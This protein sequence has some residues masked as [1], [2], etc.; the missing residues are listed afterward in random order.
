MVVSGSSNAHNGGDTVTL[1]D[2]TR[3]LRRQW[4]S[5]VVGLLI[6]L[7]L[8]MAVLAISDRVYASRA[9]VSVNPIVDDPFGVTAGN[10]QVVGA[11]EVQIAQ[12]SAVADRAAKTLA[13]GRSSADLLEQLTVRSPQ[14]SS[15]LEF[16]FEAP[17]ALLASEGANAFAQAYLDQRAAAAQALVDQQFDNLDK[18]IKALQAVLKSTPTADSV[19][20]DLLIRDISSLRASQ[21][22]AAALVVDPGT[23][24]DPGTVPTDPVA[25]NPKI[26]L[27]GGLLLGLLL[28]VLLALLGDR[29]DTRIRSG[30]QAEAAL[31]APWLA[32][33]SLEHDAR[34]R[35]VL[36]DPDGP[37]GAGYGAARAKLMSAQVG[38]GAE[39]LLVT[40]SAWDDER[41]AV[42][43]VAHNLAAALGR[44]GL[45]TVLI[46]DSE[47]AASQG[48]GR[49]P[50]AMG[51]MPALVQVVNRGADVPQGGLG[52][53]AQSS[54]WVI[55]DGSVATEPG[56]LLDLAQASDGAVFVVRE[57][58]TT[59]PAIRAMAADV[60]QMG[61]P[62]LGSIFVRSKSI[63]ARSSSAP[64][65]PSPSVSVRLDQPVDAPPSPRR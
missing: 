45:R 12:S 62:V 29:R 27:L 30:R 51:G 17:T 53:L 65:E 14:D 2:V 19:G 16:V 3:V 33:V 63:E 9:V 41:E 21:N 49:G 50:S 20:R 24:I 57:K 40:S 42:S 35:P 1:G 36:A 64:V 5:L 52:E 18:R 48:S 28:G 7:A 44:A 8:A 38:K 4:P 6:G 25:P 54:R 59:Q 37:A 15:T 34:R 47:M 61:T 46:T 23:I 26:Y 55:I 13:D 32:D 11:T 56:E 10:K 39:S 60:G 31:A 22:Q 43:Q 58:V